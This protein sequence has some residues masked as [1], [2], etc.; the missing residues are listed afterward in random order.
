[1]EY[2]VPVGEV[3][4]D[5]PALTSSTKERLGYPTQKPEALLERIIKASSQKGDVVLDPFCGC[6]TT[7]VAAQRLGR[8]W[9]GID[10]SPT[11]IKVVEQRLKK[12][13]A[14][15]NKDYISIGSPTTI[16]EL[17]ELKHFEFQNWIINEM[18]AKHSRKKVGDLGLDGY[19]TKDL[20][21]E[22][23]GI[24]VKQFE[25][26]GREWVDKFKSALER[27]KYNKGYLIGFSFSKGAVEEVARLKSA[28]GIN[29][30]L[31]KVKDLLEKKIILK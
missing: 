11:A 10:I 18:Q 25:R 21:R 17:K 19:I 26:V 8:H 22:N 4:D 12:I 7:V 24:E 15:K 2:G 31:V 6:G 28:K 3:W 20:F 27:A 9:I 14:E 23:A 29:I 13:G 1:M 5:I 30:E 16:E